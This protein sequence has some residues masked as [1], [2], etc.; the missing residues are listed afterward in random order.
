MASIISEVK[1]DLKHPD[2]HVHIASGGHLGGLWGHVLLKEL[3]YALRFSKS[4]TNFTLQSFHLEEM[5]QFFCL[6][7]APKSPKPASKC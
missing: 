2:I 7:E 4:E 5:K 3:G 1:F 6:T